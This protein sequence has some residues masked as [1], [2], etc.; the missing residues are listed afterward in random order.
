[1]GGKHGCIVRRKR[2]P[3]VRSRDSGGQSESARRQ[4]G[5]L[6]RRAD[7]EM[8]L[9]AEGIECAQVASPV[10]E[11]PYRAFPNF[12]QPRLRVV[13]IRCKDCGA[14]R[15]LDAV[16]GIPLPVAPR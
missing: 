7:S 15:P 8:H 11:D 1:M 9:A 14:Q 2:E 6:D 12:E 4:H 3:A 10:G 5:V 16:G 13:R